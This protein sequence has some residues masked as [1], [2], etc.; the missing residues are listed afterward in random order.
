MTEANPI[1][2]THIDH[3]VIRVNDLNLMMQWYGE[4]L[5]CRLERGPGANGLAQLRAG[6]SLIDLVDAGS[7][8]GRQAGA[9]PNLKAP[10]LDHVCFHLNPWD[11]AAIIHQLKKFDV[12]FSSPADRYGATGMGPSI[13]LKDHEGNNIEL[14]GSR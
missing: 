4:V 3:V 14:K 1:N 2:L 6:Q 12:E 11:E 7:E 8:L 10:N 13:Y 5:G 9:P